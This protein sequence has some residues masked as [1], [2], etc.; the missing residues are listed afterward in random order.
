MFQ[1]T[2]KSAV[3][4]GGG[5]GIGQAI[6]R[7]FARQGAIVHIL[8]LQTASAEETIAGIVAEGGRG[9]AHA[10]NVS[11]QQAVKN[12]FEKIGSFDILVNCAGIA[13]IG[14]ADNTSE[15]D[16]DKVYQVNIKG[17]YNCLH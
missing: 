5:S 7:L 14:R 11:D 10:C 8:E 12:V 16:F 15:E 3:I 9:T 13:H 2:H 6:A 4:T 1:L 17:T